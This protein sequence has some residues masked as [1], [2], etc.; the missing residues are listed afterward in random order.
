VIVEIVALYPILEPHFEKLWAKA[1]GAR[2]RLEA[3]ILKLYRK[4]PRYT[5]VIG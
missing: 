3:A 2:E 4:I 5:R 1:A